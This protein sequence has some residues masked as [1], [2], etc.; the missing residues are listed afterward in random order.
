MISY[1][2]I[3]KEYS[4]RRVNILFPM[5]VAMPAFMYESFHCIYLSTLNFATIGIIRLTNL[6]YITVIRFPMFTL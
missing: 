6:L 3:N 5:N 4:F 2:Y 1:L